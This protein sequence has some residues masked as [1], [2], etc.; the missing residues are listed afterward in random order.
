MKTLMK[1]ISPEE[2]LKHDLE[3]LRGEPI[4]QM[5]S[6]GEV[7]SF[8]VSDPEELCKA[9]LVSVRMIT[10][11]HEKYIA[12]AIEGVVNQ[13]CNFDFELI[14]GEDCSTDRTR[15]ICL[16]YQKRYPRIIRVLYSEFNLHS[17][18]ITS[19][20][21]R[22]VQASRGKYMAL[23]EGDDYWCDTE[24]LQKQVD[25]LQEKPSVSLVFSDKYNKMDTAP[26]LIPCSLYAVMR[27]PA[28]K[29]GSDKF[30]DFLKNTGVI[31]TCSAVFRSEDYHLARQRYSIFDWKIG[32]GDITLWYGL[33]CVGDVFH[34][35]ERMVV[36]RI[37]SNGVSHNSKAEGRVF[38]GGIVARIYF[39]VVAK[40]KRL[41]FSDDAMYACVGRMRNV[42]T[43]GFNERLQTFRSVIA[44][45]KRFFW[46]YHPSCLL[47]LFL[48]L[49]GFSGRIAWFPI[50]LTKLRWKIL[51]RIAP[52][53]L[54]GV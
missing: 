28:G 53:Y 8:E 48:H 44:V 40:H 4:I 2:R 38:L 37:H 20:S 12:D 42:L 54:W 10:F 25:V 3:L 14:I 18:A 26:G 22:C 52:R 24:K 1:T 33:A 47:S 43:M 29:I 39:D 13:V 9:P 17:S 23:C 50:R 51:K 19:N 45:G 41:C 35:A 15:D 7:A 30:Y 31:P 27:M 21:L 32:M 11:N 16:E 6:S 34:F 36:Y 49:A 5:T 46:F